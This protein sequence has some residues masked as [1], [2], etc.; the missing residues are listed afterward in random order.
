METFGENIRKMNDQNKIIVYGVEYS[1]PDR[2]KWEME[3]ISDLPLSDEEYKI[4]LKGYAPDWECR[5]APIEFEHWLYIIRSGLWVKKFK[6]EKQA[7]GFYH[8]TQHFTT[9]IERGHHLL[10]DILCQGYFKPSLFDAAQRTGILN[11]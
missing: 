8:L 5:Y 3:D 7:D 4:F 2:V 9:E 1:S 6:Y 11:A 10:L